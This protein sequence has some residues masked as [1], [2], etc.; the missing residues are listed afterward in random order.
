MWYA[1]ACSICEKNVPDHWTPECQKCP[2]GTSHVLCSE[3][4]TMLYQ[5]N[6]IRYYR[7]DRD[8]DGNILH[9]QQGKIYQCP[10]PGLVAALRLMGI[11]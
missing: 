8:R 5:A 11:A 7:V 2:E 4:H 9:V 3:H 6:I 10:T 1:F